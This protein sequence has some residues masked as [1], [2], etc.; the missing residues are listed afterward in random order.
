MFWHAEGMKS[1]YRRRSPLQRKKVPGHSPKAS[2]GYADKNWGGDYTSPWVWFSSCDLTSNHHPPKARDAP[3]LISA[4]DGPKLLAS[5]SIDACWSI[6]Y[7][8]RQR[9]TNTISPSSGKRATSIS[10]ARRN[11]KAKSYLAYR[12]RQFDHSRFVFRRPLPQR[13][14]AVDQLRG[15]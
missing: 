2:Y 9:N 13:G 11:E 12:G 4:E 10:I 14:H 7:I 1:H 8:R 5:R 3:S 15:P 6:S